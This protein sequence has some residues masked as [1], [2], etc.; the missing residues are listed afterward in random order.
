MSYLIEGDY[1]ESCNCLITCR[2]TFGTR[3]DVT[4]SIRR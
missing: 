4:G 2:C 3:F 1:F